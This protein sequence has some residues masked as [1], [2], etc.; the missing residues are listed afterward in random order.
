MDPNSTELL[1]VV[2]GK[3]WKQNVGSEGRGDR[4]QRAG[5]EGQGSAEQ[6]DGWYQSDELSSPEDMFIKNLMKA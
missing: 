6:K 3:G 1:G 4:G 2:G 5:A